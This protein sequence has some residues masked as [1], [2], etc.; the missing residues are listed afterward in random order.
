MLAS[1]FWEWCKIGWID[2]IKLHTENG[3]GGVGFEYT[4]MHDGS[5]EARVLASIRY[6]DEDLTSVKPSSNR[7]ISKKVVS[8]NPAI[9]GELQ[10]LAIRDFGLALSIVNGHFEIV[11]YLISIGCSLERKHRYQICHAG[12]PFVN[13][14]LPYVLYPYEY[15]DYCQILHTGKESHKRILFYI[16][17]LLS[18]RRLCAELAKNL[19]VI[20]HKRSNPNNTS[21]VD[22]RSNPNNMNIVDKRSNPNNMNIVDKNCHVQSR[23]K[24]INK[25]KKHNLLRFVLNPK[26]LRIQLTYF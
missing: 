24:L 17:S 2:D 15:L 6:T 25:I 3:C 18:K 16:L 26:S 4:S 23:L 7:Q 8:T 22:K 13:V 19:N 5:G 11:R 14:S 9:F 12:G 21:I 20:E 1:T 10:T